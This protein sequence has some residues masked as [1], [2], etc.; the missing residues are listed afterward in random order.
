MKKMDIKN[1]LIQKR[2][3][4]V[5]IA[6]D[7]HNMGKQERSQGKDSET[8]KLL[9]HEWIIRAEVVEEILYHG[10][11][12]KFDDPVYTRFME[13]DTL[14]S[15]NNWWKKEPFSSTFL[16]SIQTKLISKFI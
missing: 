15:Q 11:N 14:K 7:F 3:R 16:M 5:E 13:K 9:A 6:N 1:K 2:N 4:F 10:F 12:V 8:A